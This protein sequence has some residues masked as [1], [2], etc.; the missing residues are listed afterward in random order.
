MG[1]AKLLSQ[2]STCAR[3]AVGAV[4]TDSRILQV[5]GVGYNGNGR[6]LP[7]RCDG[8]EPGRCGCV[9]AEANALLKA[10]GTIPGKVLF[11]TRS[12]CAACAKLILNAGV[13]RVFYDEAYRDETGIEILKLGGIYVSEL[14]SVDKSWIGP[15]EPGWEPT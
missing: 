2:R 5:L 13:S 3:L 1:T 10:P 12:P 11:T 14:G 7:N 15:W 6:G 8:D 4:V 9:H